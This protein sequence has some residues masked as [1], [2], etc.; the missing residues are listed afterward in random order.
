MVYPTLWYHIEVSQPYKP[1]MLYPFIPPFLYFFDCWQ[2]LTCFFCFCLCLFVLHLFIFKQ[3]FLFLHTKNP[4]ST[5]FP[6]PTLP[7]SPHPTPMY[8]LREGKFSI[9]ESTKHLTSFLFICLVVCF[10]FPHLLFPWFCIVPKSHIVDIIWQIS[11][12]GWFLSFRNMHFFHVVLCLDRSL[13][14]G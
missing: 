5:P 11:F 3:S 1:F 8:P 4:V 13:F 7:T 10:Y 12:L 6:P 9:G 14:Y 2:H